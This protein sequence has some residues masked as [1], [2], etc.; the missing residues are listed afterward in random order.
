MQ[1]HALTY[2]DVEVSYNATSVVSGIDFSVDPG[3]IVGLVGESG[4]GKTTLIKAAMGLLGPTGLVTRGDIWFEGRSIPDLPAREL[5]KLCG[6]KLGMI[7]QDSLAS[8]CPITRI[9]EQIYEELSAHTSLT[10]AEADTQAIDMLEKLNFKDGKR[11]LESYPFELSGGMG[12]RVGICL[13]MIMRPQILF[14]D[15][16]TSALDVTTQKVVVDL[17]LEMRETYGTAIV[18]VTH[19]MGVISAMAD[20]VVVLKDGRMVE[21]GS[22]SAVLEH[23]RD[24][25]TRQLLD[26]VPHLRRKA[27]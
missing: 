4:C 9:G 6:P 19:N 5:R 14:A 24:P 1:Q 27:S 20:S 12:Q 18:V 15:E 7:F 22:T 13:A 3:E 21:S 10:R 11:I 23:P 25:Y 8:L 26:A 16:P 2:E 17:M